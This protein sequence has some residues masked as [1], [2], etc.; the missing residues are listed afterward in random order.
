MRYIV[1]A[2]ILS[3]APGLSHQ[4][5][6]DGYTFENSNQQLAPRQQQLAPTTA[7]RRIFFGDGFLGIRGL[8]R[9]AVIAALPA[10]AGVSM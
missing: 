9:G 7:T 6:D 4:Q 10:L 8:T 3:L 5:Y 1:I 2:L